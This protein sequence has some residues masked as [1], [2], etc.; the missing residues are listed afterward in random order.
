MMVSIKGASIYIPHERVSANEVAETWQAN[1]H[2]V[3]EKAVPGNSEDAVTMGLEAAKRALEATDTSAEELDALLFASMTP[4]Y[5]ISEASATL[6]AMLDAEQAF[7][8]DFRGSARSG[9]GALHNAVATGQTTLIVAS[10]VPRG[11]TGTDIDV[12]S[13]SG[14]AAVIVGPDGSIEL[15]GSWS[16]ATDFTAEAQLAN[17]A[18]ITA[19]LRF[20]R[21]QYKE[22][23][24][25]AGNS[26]GDTDRFTRAVV[27]G[28]PGESGRRGAQALGVSTDALCGQEILRQAGD[29]GA[30]LPLVRFGFALDES[31]NDDELL[32]AGYGNGYHALSF[33]V[34]ERVPVS[35]LTDL[36]IDSTDLNYVDYLQRTNQLSKITPEA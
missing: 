26:I 8:A 33:R 17:N 12:V 36:K 7:T 5:K 18:N 30:A 3:K 21:R 14:S 34:N 29:L 19:D 28:L 22:S 20:S 25:Q 32:L 2:E 16:Q 10:D 24:L 11:S 9:V 6:A 31:D 15:T 27:Q 13:G 23:L 4:P 35:G 1:P